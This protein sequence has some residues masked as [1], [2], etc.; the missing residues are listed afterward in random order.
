MAAIEVLLEKSYRH[1]GCFQVELYAAL[2]F[3]GKAGED[4]YNYLRELR[5]SIVHRGYD[6]SSA[7]SVVGDFPL[8]ISP[9]EIPNKSGN[10]CYSS[11]GSSILEIIEKVESVIGSLFIKHI[12]EKNLFEPTYSDDEKKKQII[13][14]IPK[15]PHM[16]Q[17]A[18]DMAVESLEKIQFNEIANLDATN[19]ENV[20]KY[21]S[22]AKLQA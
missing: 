21:N 22:L 7:I 3:G 9:P 14:F 11:F 12:R 4:C 19:I 16:P 20:L 6:I 8:L 10:K 17:W 15:I 5:N 2:A 18:K 1:S 13:K